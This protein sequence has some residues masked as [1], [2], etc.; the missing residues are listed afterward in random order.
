MRAKAER[1]AEL[2]EKAERARVEAEED[3]AR[4]E[5]KFALSDKGAALLHAARLELELEACHDKLAQLKSHV[6]TFSLDFMS[7]LCVQTA[8]CCRAGCMAAQFEQR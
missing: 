2:L 4:M 5:A 3:R 6:C 8:L 7:T 1:Q